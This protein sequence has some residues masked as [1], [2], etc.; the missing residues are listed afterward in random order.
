MRTRAP[1]AD[2]RVVLGSTD[3]DYL[4]SVR[5]AF[6]VN[7]LLSTWMQVICSPTANGSTAL[8]HFLIITVF[9]YLLPVIFHP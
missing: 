1:A 8:H 5:G 2:S 6:W 7:S 4:V 9:A 3:G